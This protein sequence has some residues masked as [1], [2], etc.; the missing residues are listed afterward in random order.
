MRITI[1]SLCYILFFCSQISFFF[2]S[3]QFTDVSYIIEKTP[4]IK[5]FFQFETNNTTESIIKNQNENTV[6]TNLNENA[7]RGKTTYSN[8]DVNE[9]NK[10]NMNRLILYGDLNFAKRLRQV[11]N[12]TAIPLVNDI[13]VSKRNNIWEVI[14]VIN[15]GNAVNA[16]KEEYR[17]VDV[18]LIVEHGNYRNIFKGVKD[19]HSRVLKYEVPTMPVSGT[20]SLFDYSSNISYQHLPY[21]ALV[22]HPKRK[23]AICAYISNFNTINEIKSFLAYYIL[24]R[25]DNIIFYC[26]SADL[27]YFRIS[28]KKEIDS[29][30]VI[31]YEYPWPLPRGFVPSLQ[32]SQINSCYYRHR[33]YFEYIISQDVDEYFYSELYPYDLYSAIR[34]VY[35]L[36][37]DKRSLAV[38]VFFPFHL[39]TII[40]LSWEYKQGGIF[41]KW[42]FV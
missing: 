11:Q 41:R 9:A 25:I 4:G 8:R 18:E 26:R 24:Q 39:G 22:Y 3:S 7:I 29:G 10:Y 30:F 13:I 15:N 35:E 42:Y 23:I 33:N 34:R 27:N 37:P 1:R 6:V 20:I 36:N 5:H 38:F 2:F 19:W 32:V 16:T 21:R 40:S 14:V 17:S 31:L 12:N 28:L